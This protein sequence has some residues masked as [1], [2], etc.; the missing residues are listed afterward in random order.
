M[1]VARES[2]MNLC[3]LLL[4]VMLPVLSLRDKIN[5]GQLLVL[6]NSQG[7]LLREG[8]VWLD[9]RRINLRR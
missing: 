9:G 6:H 2:D 3:E 4:F 8:G 7:F 5:L 1:L